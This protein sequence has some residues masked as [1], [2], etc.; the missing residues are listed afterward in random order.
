MNDFFLT[1]ITLIPGLALVAVW[2]F[3]GWMIERARR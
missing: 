1:T 3:V 2:F